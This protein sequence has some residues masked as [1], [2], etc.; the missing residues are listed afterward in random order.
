[1]FGGVQLL[2]W[3]PKFTYSDCDVPTTFTLRIPAAAWRPALMVNGGFETATSGVQESFG[4][5]TDRVLHC[6]LRFTEEEWHAYV[7]PMFKVLHEQ[8]QAFT[9]QLDAA[10]V[11]TSNTVRLVSPVAGEEVM[12]E[13]NP[14]DGVLELM[15]V[16]RTDDGSAFAGP[17]YFPSLA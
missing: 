2:E 13:F 3:V 6:T 11:A 14:F 4:T 16:V 15:I 1:M 12:P 5:R 7:D 8:A 10:D 9:F 17:P